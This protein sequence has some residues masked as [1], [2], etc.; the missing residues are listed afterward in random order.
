VQLEK[1][2]KE[3][4]KE[5]TKAAR[6]PSETETTGTRVRVEAAGRARTKEETAAV[7]ASGVESW[8]TSRED[9]EFHARR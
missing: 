6:H 2:T 1:N 8:A 7:T 3:P 9:A 5:K 4:S